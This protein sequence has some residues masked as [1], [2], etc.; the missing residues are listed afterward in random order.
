MVAAHTVIIPSNHSFDDPDKPISH[1]GERSQGIEIGQDV[2][3]GCGA[4]VLDGVSLG[5]GCVIGAGAVV[6]RSIETNC[7]AVGVPARVI[8]V[9]GATPAA[10]AAP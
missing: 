6:T 9:R 2:W 3:I 8:G 4:R 10:L 1:Q 7:V 5:D